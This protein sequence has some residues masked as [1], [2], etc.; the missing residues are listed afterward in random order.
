MTVHQF[1]LGKITC[2]FIPCYP[3]LFVSWFFLE[4]NTIFTR[5]I[6]YQLQSVPENSGETFQYMH[7]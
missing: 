5:H 3:T 2:N 6:Q 1:E 7:F 4:Q